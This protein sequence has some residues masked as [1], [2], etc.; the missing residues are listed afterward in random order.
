MT[1][2]KQTRLLFI[3]DI[4]GE[5]GLAYLEACLPALVEHHQPTFVI[6][7]AENIDLSPTQSGACGMRTASLNRLFSLPVDLVT[8]GNH[9]WDGEEGQTVHADMRVLRPLNYGE[10]A[11][12]RGAAVLEKGGVRLGV[13]NLV[14]KTALRFADE[15]IDALERQLTAWS[16]AVDL[17]LVDFHGESVTEKLTFAFAF[18]GRVAAVVGT[19][20][21]VQTTDTRIL[22]QGTA[23]VT[24]VGMTGPGGG[25]QGYAP[26]RFVNSLRLRLPSTDSFTLASGEVEL[27]AVLVTCEGA[28]AV[29]IVRV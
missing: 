20:T 5:S 7:N 14:S 26:A 17:V 1:L 25:I 10:H 28:R 21:H 2:E 4:V 15:A 18:D 8:G 9:S 6:A 22:P 3:G 16:G 23:Y 29:E 13:V 24:D 27:G 12:G 11:P 19:H